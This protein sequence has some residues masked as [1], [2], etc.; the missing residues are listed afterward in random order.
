MKA[1]LIKSPEFIRAH[2]VKLIDW[3][4]Q[5]PSGVHKGQERYAN[6]SWLLLNFSG[7]VQ[8]DRVIYTTQF[9]GGTSTYVTLIWIGQEIS[10]SA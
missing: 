1:G 9:K 7:I 5:E 8:D 10:M 2:L 3:P 4:V 6:E